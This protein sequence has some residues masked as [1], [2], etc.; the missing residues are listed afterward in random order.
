MEPY[1]IIQFGQND[2]DNGL[3][4]AWHQAIAW[5]NDGFLLIR[6]SASGAQFDENLIKIQQFSVKKFIALENFVW[7]MAA[8]Q[9]SSVLNVLTT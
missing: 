7:K 3:W 9:F 2:S 1:A 4:H 5:T 6:P 8:I